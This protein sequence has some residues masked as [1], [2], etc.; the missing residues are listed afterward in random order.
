MGSAV[1]DV[2]ELRIDALAAGGDGVGR[3]ADGRVVFVPM[4][5]PGDCVKARITALHPRYAR[6]ALEQ[7]DEPSPA[8]VEPPCAVFGACGGCSWQHVDYAVQCEAKRQ[9]AEDA[10]RRVGKLAL[11]GPVP[12]HP[13][14]A[15]YAYRARAR[16]A[17]EAGRVGYRRAHSR[18]LCAVSHCPV[19][20]E[21]ADA[22][23]RAL[24]AGPPAR[25]GEWEIAAGVSGARA[26][27]VGGTGPA[28]ELDVAGGKLRVSPGVFFQANAS[29][30]AALVAS[31]THAA[32]HGA[33]ALELYAGCG[34]FTLALARVFERVIAVEADV[35]A[36]A[37]L[38][39]NLAR[40]GASGVEV[41]HERV[42]A[43]LAGGRVAA[44]RPDAVVLD[45]PRTG[46]PRGAAARIAALAPVRIAYLSCDPATLARDLAAL[47]AG[48]FA[49]EA[50]EAF[51]LFPHTPHV[52]VLAQLRG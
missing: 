29:L 8:R 43:A 33:L 23:L 52:E 25:D 10:L 39:H 27:E 22:Q 46:L 18:E 42:E 5:A 2:V 11:P 15:P 47:V 51:D 40:A 45:P 9:I 12:L 28:L 3:T 32:G 44:V 17:V 30:H 7:V 21:P 31:M 1:G 50:V 14:P 4:T 24:A 16:V 20:S 49:L 38:R 37:D 26:H 13:S 6:A 34:F 41:V 35:A 48:G 36:V 19:L